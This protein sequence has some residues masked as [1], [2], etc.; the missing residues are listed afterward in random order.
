[1]SYWIWDPH[2]PRGAPD[3]VE[4]VLTPSDVGPPS[5]SKRF[6]V[7]VL[8][9]MGLEVGVRKVTKE[10][11]RASYYTDYLKSKDWRDVW[12]IVWR[13]RIETDRER[14][15][16]RVDERD[17]ETDAFA[18]TTI[19]D[20]DGPPSARCLVVA[21]FGTER[22]AREAEKAIVGTSLSEYQS[23]YRV[24]P[25][26]VRRFGIKPKYVQLQFDIGRFPLEFYSS[27][28]D[29]AAAVGELCRRQRGTLHF[30]D[31]PS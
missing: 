29:Y 15:R 27:G 26:Q 19:E 14:V 20:P 30:D 9:D 12:P 11:F 2:V 22:A 7:A 31:R 13:Y 3:S 16:L 18:G 24:D 8:R 28:A 4:F 25:P 17:T 23:R 10:T 6:V 21:D 1:M 5:A